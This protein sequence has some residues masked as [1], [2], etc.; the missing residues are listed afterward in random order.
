[1]MFMLIL[2]LIPTM[3]SVSSIAVPLDYIHLTI[4]NLAEAEPANQL[5]YTI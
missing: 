5:E 4:I 3:P 1:M 2:L